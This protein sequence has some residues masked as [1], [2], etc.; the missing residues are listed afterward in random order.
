MSKKQLRQI[1][2][3]QVTKQ[4]EVELTSVYADDTKRG[5]PKKGSA[6]D[7][8]KRKRGLAALGGK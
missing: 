1:K 5:R 7:P 6:D 4:G 3:T 2:K 8:R